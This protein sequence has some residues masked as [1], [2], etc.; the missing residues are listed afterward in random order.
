M[1]DLDAHDLAAL[2]AMSA[3]I[4]RDPL[5]IQGAGG[6]SSL[7]IEGV[8]WVK[9]SG[10]WLQDAE[11]TP[12][13]LA[14]DLAQ[15][16]RCFAAGEEKIAPLSVAG[17]PTGLRPSIETSLHAFL[18]QAIVLHVHSVNAL[19]WCVREEGPR[20]IGRRLEGLNWA[21]L[22]YCRPGLPLSREAAALA[23]RDVAPDVLLLANHGL[24]VAGPECA[25][26]EGL[27]AEVEHRLRLD[28]RPAPAPQT[29]A[30]QRLAMSSPYRPA[31]SAV[32]HGI[33]TDPRCLGTAGAG[34][35]YPD[36]VVFLGPGARV[37]ADDESPAE[38]AREA[39]D[40]GVAPPALLL[41]PRQGTLLRSDLP[42]EALA[43]AE[44]LGEVLARLPEEAAA[45]YIGAAEEQALLGWD[46]ET[47]RKSLKR[48]VP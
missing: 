38:I 30:L 40:A 13:F 42:P 33:A 36:H 41:A 5:L 22:G 3:R 15:A 8:L 11:R 37:L 21:W 31:A 28:P 24:V 4:G 35:L 19:A 16:R 27:L 1:M 17:A 18:P 23:R 2:K 48:A 25:R 26:V 46:A 43:L 12:I 9:A 7:K 6:N 20:A 39:E 29:E 14:L 47:Y 45:S 32:V 34:S 44:C 10:T